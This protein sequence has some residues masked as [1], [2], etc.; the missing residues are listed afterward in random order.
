M[1]LLVRGPGLSAEVQVDRGARIVSLRGDDGYQWL[2][3]S[4]PTQRAGPGQP[5]VR[6]GMGGWDEVAPTVQADPDARDGAG[7]RL[8]VLP[9][10]GDV[11]NV[12]WTVEAASPTVLTT[13][14][15]LT[16]MPVRLERTIAANATG[17]TLRYRAST[18]S[19]VPLP[20]LWCAHPQFAAGAGASLSIEAAGV[21]LSP[22]LTEMY[23]QEGTLRS[24]PA[25]PLHS[26]LAPGSSR[27]V[28]VDP[29]E[30]ADTVVLSLDS[31]RALRIGWDAAQ[32]PYLGLF[33]DN[34]EFAAEPVIAVE[35]STGWGERLSTAAARQRVL[36]LSRGRPLEWEL[37]LSTL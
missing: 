21:S 31:G 33:W 36:T 18:D 37:Q 30:K 2:A 26:E 15:K 1:N 35:P 14:V 5:F 9:D 23:P 29:A 8:G 28:F 32:L 12:A 4:E 20:L 16:S 17:L 25:G 19:A 22:A 27:K 13:S 6:T 7:S 11:W 24:F 3:P 10:H 34:G